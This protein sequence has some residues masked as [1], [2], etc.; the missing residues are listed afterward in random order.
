MVVAL[1]L[2]AATAHAQY[3]NRFTTI[4]NGAI[5]FTG[6][7]LGLSKAV[8][9]NQAGT[10]DAIGTFTT[11]NTAL[12]VPTYP[13][14]TTL[15]FAQNSASATLNLPAGSTVLYAELT[16]GGSYGFGGQDVSGSRN[17]SITLID[18]SGKSST[19]SPDP[20]FQRQLGSP[21][22]GTCTSTCFYVRTA[23]VTNQIVAG[24][25]GTYTV[26]SVPATDGASDNTNNCAGWTLAVVY[27]NFSLRWQANGVK[28]KRRT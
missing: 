27:R 24:G 21:A 3:V 7:T 14:G 6:N 19:I 18:P 28:R 23:K 15:A 1:L 13:P 25:A 22:T 2:R 11:I 16:W 8:G 17:N 26:G 5:T 4:T 9:L 10:S 12:Q 20:T